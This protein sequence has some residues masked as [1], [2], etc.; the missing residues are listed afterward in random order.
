MNE[1]NIEGY[2]NEL[3]LLVNMDSGQGNPDGISA[4][5][6]FFVQRFGA[7]GWIVEKRKPSP[8]TGDCVIVKN[9]EASHYDALLTGHLDTVFPK[10]ETAKRPFL[11][12]AERAYG[13]GVLDMKQGCLAMLY[14]LEALP[15]AVTDALNIVAIFNPDEEI[16]SIYSAGI[17]GEYAAMSRYAFVFEAAST[18]GSHTVERKGRTALR[19]KLRG[20]AGH[21]GYLFDGGSL[22]A[23]NEL[24]YWINALHALHSRERGTSVNVGVLHADGAANIVPD[25]AMMEV[26][27]R[28]ESMSE[29]ETLTR[30]IEELK[31]HAKDYGASAE[32]DV[33]ASAPPLTPDAKTMKYAE[34]MR[35]ISE[36]IG[37]PFK[38]R[39]RGGVS[40]A[41]HIAARGPVCVDGLGPTGDFDHSDREYLELSTVEPS[42]RFARAL[43]CDLAEQNG[44]RQ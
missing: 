18:D 34:R 23:V 19:V 3:E 32:I 2:L 22:S 11:R 20:V 28:Y 10:G 6:D 31:A 44:K 40:D 1:F 24:V 43:L 36:R 30:T 17:I 26:E 7:M 25:T 9:R 33:L 27:A 14:V 37:V 5:G 41:N 29:Y 35:V 15:K 4:V 42:L 38:I 8:D 16:G 13:V 39:K 21:A 12:D